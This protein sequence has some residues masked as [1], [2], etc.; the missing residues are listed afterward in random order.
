MGRL[1]HA[2][3]VLFLAA[4]QDTVP[5]QAC[6]S[7]NSTL[8]H[9]TEPCLSQFSYLTKP[10]VTCNIPGSLSQLACT[11]PMYMT[12]AVI[13]LTSLPHCLVHFSAHRSG[14]ADA[15]GHPHSHHHGKDKKSKTKSKNI[16]SRPPPAGHII[17]G[18]IGSITKSSP[19]PAGKSN[20]GA[21]NLHRSLLAKG[22]D[23]SGSSGNGKLSQVCTYQSHTQGMVGWGVMV[24]MGCASEVKVGVGSH[25]LSVSLLVNQSSHPVRALFCFQ[26]LQPYDYLPPHL[27]LLTGEVLRTL[28]CYK[29]CVDGLNLVCQIWCPNL[30]E[31]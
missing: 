23:A 22:Y 19:P 2:D 5:D 7:F 26:W 25:C 6:C 9:A 17:V 1:F 10:F 8:P 31:W 29:A 30:L 12:H 28:G 24:T 3:A 14:L 27:K 21:G 11:P 16:L 18:R 15:R 4:N 13:R 20:R